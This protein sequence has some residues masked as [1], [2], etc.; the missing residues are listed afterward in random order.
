L[1]GRHEGEM[2]GWLWRM[3]VGNFYSCPH[4]QWE[5]VKAGTINEGSRTTGHYYEMRCVKCGDYMVRNLK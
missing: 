2:L 3:I 4:P 1:V 5:T